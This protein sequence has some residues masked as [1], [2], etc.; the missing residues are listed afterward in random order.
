MIATE[1]TRE[2]GRRGRTC[3]NGQLFENKAHKCVL[4]LILYCGT[5]WENI[6][7]MSQL[8][9]GVRL[10]GAA[11]EQFGASAVALSGIESTGLLIGL[12]D[13]TYPP[14]GKASFVA[15]SNNEYVSENF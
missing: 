9:R 13:T 14:A 4:G 8:E 10:F 11:S 6:K 1:K 5:T 7:L 15:R 2:T 3:P 12:R